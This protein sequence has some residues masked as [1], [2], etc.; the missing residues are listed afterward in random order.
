MRKDDT[1]P[2]GLHFFSLIGFVP[3][4]FPL[5]AEIG[6]VCVIFA[7]ETQVC[8]NQVNYLLFDFFFF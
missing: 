7:I 6:F 4:M 5:P 3:N 1:V 8:R 2:Y